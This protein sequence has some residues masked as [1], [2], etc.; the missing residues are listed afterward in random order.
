[1][2]RLVAGHAAE[3]TE[4][5]VTM[6]QAKVI[7]VVMASGSVHLTEL[8][9]RLRVSPSTASE[10]VDRLVDLELL[11]RRDDPVDR[12]HVI[13]TAT[14]RAA[15]L[16]ER[17]RELNQRELRDLL[18]QLDAEELDV[19]ARSIE[20]FGQAIDRRTASTDDAG[21]SATGQQGVT[22]S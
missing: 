10:Q 5:N 16:M 22:P 2:H 20:I 13:V 19:V 21:V 15:R 1:M 7:Y 9:G 11:E 12:R 17:F 18:G 4:V 14:D 6:A 3:F 8:A